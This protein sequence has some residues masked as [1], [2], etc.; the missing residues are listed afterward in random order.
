M[1]CCCENILTLCDVDYCNPVIKSPF[2]GL[3]AGEYEIQLD[4]LNSTTNHTVSIDSDGIGLKGLEL[5][6][7]HTYTMRIIGKKVMVNS[8]EYD[9]FRFTTK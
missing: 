9:C 2:N 1:S 8:I 3:T 7:N 4:F 5:N 6:E